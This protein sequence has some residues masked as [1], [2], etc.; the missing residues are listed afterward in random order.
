VAI[1]IFGFYFE[2]ASMSCQ[3]SDLGVLAA[4]TLLWIVNLGLPA[5]AGT[6]FV[7]RMNFFRKGDV[8]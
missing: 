7:F 2:Q 5:I 3:K 4:S 1:Y 6:I 8:S